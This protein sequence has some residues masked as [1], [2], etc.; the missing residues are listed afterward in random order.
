MMLNRIPNHRDMPLPSVPKK[1]AGHDRRFEALYVQSFIEM[2]ARSA[3]QRSS[4][5]R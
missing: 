2:R 1:L 4:I 3:K 5:T